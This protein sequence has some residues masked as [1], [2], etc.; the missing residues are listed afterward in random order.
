MN[1]LDK[2]Y[3]D[4]LQDILENGTKKGDRT[5]TGTI[6]VF[7]R[8]I[9]HNMKD[10]FPLLTSKKM[11]TKQIITE[12]LWFLRGET[13][14]Q[15]LVQDGNYIW[16]GDAYKK[17]TTYHNNHPTIHSNRFEILSR[18]D[19]IEKIK[20]DNDFA[21]QWGDLGPIYGK[22]W[23]KWTSTYFDKYTS[24]DPKDLSVHVDQIAEMIDK[25]KNRP[26]DRR[27][28]VTA[29]NP[30]EVDAATLPPCHYGFQVWTRELSISERNMIMYDHPEFDV[31]DVPIGKREEEDKEHYLKMDH[32]LCDGY[33]VPRRGISLLWNQR[34][35]DTPLG[36]PFNIA[37]YGALLQILAQTVNMVPEEL[38][39]NL[40]D[41]H[42]YLNQVDAVKEQLKR[43][44]HK[45]PQL[46]IEIPK[47]M[48]D[49]AELKYENFKL[50]NYI[51]EDKIAF[52]LSN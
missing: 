52:E 7:G 3:Q 48:T 46:E 45:L 16:V 18:K 27:N 14:I 38:I 42:I 25:L 2:Q 26:D 9:R 40:G 36:I 28:M 33:N 1:N 30:A 39:G 15:S 37:S 5:G 43:A 8:Q 10:G 17:Y 51:S 23:R 29:W 19:F 22:Q 6:S 4:L 35:C 11:A 21:K 12:L 20:T 24:Q 41:T 13:N 32:Q 34:S 31:G 44:S 47:G 49:P 50:L